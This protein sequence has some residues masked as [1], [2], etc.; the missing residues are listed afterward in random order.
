MTL[1]ELTE[2]FTRLSAFLKTSSPELGSI[3]EKTYYHNNWFTEDNIDLMLNSITDNFLDEQKIAKWSSNY[4][5]SKNNDFSA[6]KTVGLVMAGNIPLVGFHDLFCV[7]FSGNKALVKLSSKDNI[8]LP[9]IVERLFEFNPELK[10]YIVFTDILKNINAVIATGS[11]NSAR[12]FEYYFKKYP[13]IIR[14]NRGSVAVLTGGESKDD[15]FNLGKDIFQYFG[16][17][18]RNVSKLYVPYDYDFTFFFDT[19]ELYKKIREHGKYMNNY[20][21]NRTILMMNKVPHLA[22]DFLMITEDERI[23]SPIASLHYEF[24]TDENDLKLKL[25]KHSGDIQCV[26]GKNFPIP[27]G[28]TQ[29]PQLWDYADNVNIM[30]FLYSLKEP[31]PH[32]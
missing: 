30:E 11:N 15:I 16:L 6:P 32:S 4:P 25:E 26:A 10:D 8:L 17:G 31:I 27:F 14:R 19:L 23:I 20:D 2:A 21:Y 22:S 5:A 13:H 24:Y 29:Q 12:Y 7:L 1:A 9:F 18:C 3:K 28:K